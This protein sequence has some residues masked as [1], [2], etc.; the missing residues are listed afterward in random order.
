MP[1][2]SK[3]CP[4][5]KRTRLTPWNT[6]PNSGLRRSAKIGCQ[7]IVEKF[8]SPRGLAL[9][10]RWELIGH[11]QSNKVKHAVERVGRIQSAD[12]PKLLKK[13]SEESAKIGKTMRV[14]LQINSGNDPAKFGVDMSEAPDLLGFALEQKN[15]KVEGIMAV[16]PLDSNLDTGDKMF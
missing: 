1:P 16:A 10:I 2:K 15:L 13:I 4:S 3:Y 12:S 11:L 8:D 14:L 9:K 5:P 6:P 7:E